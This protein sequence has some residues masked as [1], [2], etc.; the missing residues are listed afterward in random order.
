MEHNLESF[1]IIKKFDQHSN[2]KN[3]LL[4]KINSA[5]TE[6]LD[7]KDNYYTDNIN[8]L[9]WYDNCNFKREWVMV[10]FKDLNNF[11]NTVFQEIGY[12]DC[13]IKNIWFQQYKEKGTHGWH[14]HGYTFTG[15]YYLDLPEGS[16]CTEIITPF[17]Q[18]KLITLDVKEGD[19]SIFPSYTIHRSPINKTKFIKT[20]VSF[21]L[22]IG[23]PTK[24]IL[25]KIDRI[26]NE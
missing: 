25:N 13:V 23:R 1:Y 19:I 11:F 15:A 17:N 20:I 12:E 6:S 10:V 22:E 5:D 21:N 3:L 26:C 2:L 8:R 18:D 16:P 7:V 14:T 4:D 9:D 24:K